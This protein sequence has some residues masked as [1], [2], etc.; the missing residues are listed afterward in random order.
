VTGFLRQATLVAVF[1]TLCTVVAACGG[2]SSGSSNPN[3]TN[4]DPAHTTLKAAGLEVCSEE[5]SQKLPN[6]PGAQYTKKFF[7]A[8]DC[9]G[10]KTS[11]NVVAVYQYSSLQAVDAGY[12]AIKAAMPKNA[13]IEK[14][15]PLV[16][17]L[18][19]PNSSQYMA[20]INQ[21]LKATQGGNQ[22]TTT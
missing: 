8:P 17:V 6:E 14:Y 10:K 15:G 13:A 20:S 18:N 3:S 11:P 5:Q 7:V 19:G 4:Y 12:A 22:A 2:G 1:V 21:A 16:I 9:N